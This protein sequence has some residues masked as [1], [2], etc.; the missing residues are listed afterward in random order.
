MLIW[1]RQVG[2]HEQS[3]DFAFL[4]EQPSPA[5]QSDTEEPG[6]LFANCHFR[7]NFTKLLPH[8]HAHLC[9]GFS[10]AFQ[11]QKFL[12]NILVHHHKP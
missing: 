8:C 11:H 12:Y 6:V 3:H 7:E 2:S 4:A 5:T 1:P 9:P 10:A